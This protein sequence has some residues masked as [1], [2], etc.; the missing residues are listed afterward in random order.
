[1]EMTGTQGVAAALAPPGPLLLDLF[2]FLAQAGDPVP[3]PAAVDLQPGLA[4][5][6][7]PDAAGEPGQGVVLVRQVRQPV[8]QLGHLHLE[9]ALV[10]PGP[11]SEDVQDQLGPVQDPQF[12]HAPQVAGLGGGQVLVQEKQVGPGVQGLQGHLDQLAPAHEKPGVHLLDL[13]DGPAHRLHSG[14]GGQGRQ[15]LQGGLQHLPGLLGHGEKK[16]PVPAVVH[17]QPALGA[18][19]LFFQGL[20]NRDAVELQPGKVGCGQDF[21]PALGGIRTRLQ[22]GRLDPAGQ[23]FR[24]HL[25]G[26]GQVQA[27]QGQVG[28]I[29]PVQ[30][31]AGKVGV[32]QPEPPQAKVGAPLPGQSRQKQPRGVAHHHQGH[33]AGPVQ[34]QPDLAAQFGRQFA[35]RPGPSRGKRCGED[36]SGGGAGC[37]AC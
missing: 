27:Q 10:G 18:G 26:R 33:V 15:L 9:L 1:M 5:A 7:G 16:G 34:E 30:P 17:G 25:Q 14:G 13:L 3:G 37:S 29:V 24:V 4:R 36:R 6:P 2:Q 21:H 23:P 20:D 31:A 11:L 32:D 22:M 35:D 19:Q 28:Q 12:G 8:A